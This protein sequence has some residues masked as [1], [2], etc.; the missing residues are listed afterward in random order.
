MHDDATPAAEPWAHPAGT[1]D[2]A[3]HPVSRAAALA[4]LLEPSDLLAAV[5]VLPT[6]VSITL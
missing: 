6:T 3:A 2:T 5:S 1:I 4:G